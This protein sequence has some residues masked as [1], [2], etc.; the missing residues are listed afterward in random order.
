[1]PGSN[2]NALLKGGFMKRLVKVLGTIALVA[3]VGF[4]FGSC[5]INVA[6][7]NGGTDTSALKGYWQQDTDLWIVEI[8]GRHGYMRDWGS[9]LAYYEQSA[10][11]KGYIKVGNRHIQDLEKTDDLTWTGQGLIIQGTYVN[12]PATGVEWRDITIRLDAGGNIFRVYNRPSNSFIAT[13]RRY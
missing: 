3:I 2:Q 4:S 9:G 13:Y 12:Q 7:D 11:N 8:Q 1:V 10:V 6:D 5:V